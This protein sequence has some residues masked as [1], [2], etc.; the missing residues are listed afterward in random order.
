MNDSSIIKIDNKSISLWRHGKLIDVSPQIAVLTVDEA[1]VSHAVSVDAMRKS[2]KMCRD[3]WSNLSEEPLS[4]SVQGFRHRADLVYQH[5]NDIKERVGD[6]TDIIFAVPS[7]LSTAQLSLLLGISNALSL[8]TKGFVDINI[9]ALANAATPGN[10]SVLDIQLNQTVLLDI[11]VTDKVTAV[12][13]KIIPNI[14][15]KNIYHS[16]ARY[17]SDSFI[18]QTRFDPLHDSSSEQRLLENLPRWVDELS[19]NQELHCSLKNKGDIIRAIVPSD[20][21][22]AIISQNLNTLSNLIAP[23]RTLAFARDSKIFANAT[24]L[25]NDSQ[26]IPNDAAINGIKENISLITE[27]NNAEFI[28]ELC[29]SSKPS[30]RLTINPSIQIIDPASATHITDGERAV[31]LSHNPVSLDKNGFLVE[32]HAQE[33]VTALIENDFAIL[34]SNRIKLAVNGM[35]VVDSCQIKGGDEII[36][37]N[38]PGSFTAIT[39]IN[40]DAS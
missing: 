20:K 21:L 25:F 27:A 5:L 24:A 32:A 38:G 18:R 16:C 35:T 14:G 9:A 40:D 29:A 15:S 33:C 34:R 8:V 17:I 36:I 3:Y 31:R 39:V 12:S 23:E 37:S 6:L 11:N 19:F 2:Q 13:S 4:H 1:F 22:K 30:M 26:N 7:H 28:T 10:Y